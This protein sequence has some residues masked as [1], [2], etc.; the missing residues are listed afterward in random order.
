MTIAHLSSLAVRYIV[1]H[2][3]SYQLL[4]ISP[5]RLRCPLKLYAS[6]VLKNILGDKSI[7]VWIQLLSFWDYQ[8]QVY[9]L[10]DY[11]I[12]IYGRHLYY[13]I[14]YVMVYIYTKYF[15]SSYIIICLK[16]PKATSI[17]SQSG[18][19]N[20]LYHLS[21]GWIHSPTSFHTLRFS[22]LLHFFQLLPFGLP[23]FAH[24]S[25]CVRPCKK[26]FH[27]WCSIRRPSHVGK[28]RTFS[29]RRYFLHLW[30]TF[31]SN[32]VINL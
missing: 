4:H 13:I 30:A 7:H 2:L 10:Q 29:S 25:G 5:N 26:Y 17:F 28:Y 23:W 31:H 8:D 32:V 16:Y 15:K 22:N 19:T 20:F 21:T 12:G 18:C 14:S 27:S 1:Y 6:L 24:P 11:N 3:I 9:P